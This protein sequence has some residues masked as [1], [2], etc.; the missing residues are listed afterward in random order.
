MTTHLTLGSTSSRHPGRFFYLFLTQVLLLVLFPYLETPGLPTVFIRLLGVLAF[1][2][3]VYAVSEKRAQWISAL[4][5]AL[6]SGVLNTLYA[7][8]PT[9]QIAVPTL[10]C[11]LMFLVFALAFL[12]RAVLRVERVTPDTIYGAVSVY[13]LM[14]V[15]W[16]AAYLLL[17]TVQ[18]G[19]FSMD[20]SRH[21]NQVMGWTDC[22]FFSFVTLTTIGYGDI[23]PMTPHA[24]SLSILEAVG[25]TL[26]VAVLIS[27][28]VG[29]Y[30]AANFGRGPARQE[31]SSRPGGEEG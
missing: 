13:L 20:S 30:S 23:V 22:M 10:V 11:S 19:A 18:P 2:S 15:L 31:G 9:P 21:P 29:L 7:L 16:A 26:Y 28:L 1:L 14:A 12:L 3:C 17:E 25:G 6:P 5:L 24:R 27:R 8:R 4:V